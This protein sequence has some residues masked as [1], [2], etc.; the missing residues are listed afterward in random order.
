MS[1]TRRLKSLTPALQFMIV[2]QVIEHDDAGNITLRGIF[3]R[4]HVVAPGPFQFAFTV[5]VQY[6]GGTGEHKHWLKVTP[7]NG[8]SDTT[9]ENSFWL[10]SKAA[11]HR[12][13]TRV[14][15]GIGPE[16]VGQ[17]QFTA[18]LDGHDILTVP[19]AFDVEFVL[20]PAQ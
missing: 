20:P 5:A 13:D 17:W 14:T 19:L 11:S 6:R 10:S 4:V 7:P 3:D 16:R 12:V 2:C 1:Q 15:I 8:E 9:N 18:V